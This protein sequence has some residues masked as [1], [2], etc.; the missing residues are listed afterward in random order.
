MAV[1]HDQRLDLRGIDFQQLHVAVD[2]RRRPTVIE[3]EAALGIT[4]L[5]LQQ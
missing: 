5:R 3:Q 2:G 4:A 1:A